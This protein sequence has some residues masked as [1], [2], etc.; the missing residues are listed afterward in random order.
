MNDLDNFLENTKN[1][2]DNIVL[3]KTMSFIFTIGYIRNIKDKIVKSD[4]ENNCIRYCLNTVIPVF[5]R[6]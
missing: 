3:G 1:Y 5:N 2:P 4:I 6:K